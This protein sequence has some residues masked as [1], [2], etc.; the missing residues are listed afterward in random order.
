MRD[1]RTYLWDMADRARMALRMVDGLTFEHF[2]ADDKTREAT[3]YQIALIG[4][5]ASK[6]SIST[7]DL[8]P[9]LPFKQMSAMRNIVIHV[10]WGVR[11]ENV[12]STVNQDFPILIEIIDKYLASS[13][14]PPSTP[15]P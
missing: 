11:M 4:E 8:L 7:R 13:A 6:I 1:E 9:N 10:Y 3:I 2:L 12:W 5:G 15:D 14:P